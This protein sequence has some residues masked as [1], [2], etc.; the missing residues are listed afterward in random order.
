MKDHYEKFAYDYDEFG[1]I[2]D[3]LNEEK[4]FFEKL[5]AKYKA[6]T[7]LDC[8]CGTGHHLNMFSEMGLEVSGSDYSQSMIQV[9]NKNL[10]H[11]GK[12]IP[13]TQ[14]DFRYLE[15]V[16]HNKFDAIVC[17]ATALPHLHT[18]EDLFT[19]LT[20]MY[21]KLN[22]NGLLILTQGTTHYTLSLPS[23]E[24]VV[25]RNEFS[26]IFVKEHD[27]QFQTIHVLDL[28]HSEKRT[29]YNQYDMAY[30]ILLDDDYKRL[31]TEAGFSD[32]HIY[33]DYEMNAYDK[34]S[35]RLVVVGMKQ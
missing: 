14:C 25:N 3:Y 10:H 7:V 33:G 17:L 5:F 2:A 27:D 15:K 18:D 13:V 11:L 24:V 4:L 29:E 34:Q 22:Q 16:Y 23:I 28:F 8:A 26:R 35:R 19:A 9:T 32:I 31:L 30:R 6:H 1:S 12:E 21:N 20:S